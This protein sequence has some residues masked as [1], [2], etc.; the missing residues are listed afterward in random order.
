[1]EVGRSRVLHATLRDEYYYD[2]V[3]STYEAPLDVGG[4][5]ENISACPDF[6]FNGNSLNRVVGVGV[7]VTT[8][9]KIRIENNRFLNTGQEGIV[10]SDD[11]STHYA[12]GYVKDVAISGNA[13]MNCEENAILIKPENKKFAGPVHNNI[14][15][16]NNLF[17]I[18]NIYAV[19]ISDSANILLRDNVYKGK[20]LNYRWVNTKNVVNITTD[21]PQK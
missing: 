7:S 8:R 2:I 11:A 13:F 20:P 4:V 3:L 19:N 16:E 17:I 18:N 10:I 6:E 15:I 21:T 9:G 5:V 14:L 1:L 12:S